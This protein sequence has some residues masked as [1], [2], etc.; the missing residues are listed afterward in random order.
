MEP[1]TRKTPRGWKRI[2]KTATAV[3]AELEECEIA[4]KSDT[5]S[6]LTL[7]PAAADEASDRVAGTLTAAAA[8]SREVCA[9]CGGGGDPV[10]RT[11]GGL[12]T[13]CQ[14]CRAKSDEGAAARMAATETQAG[15]ARARGSGRQG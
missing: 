13:R 4:I 11:D 9:G 1:Q 6:W 12:T 14:D 2:E 15:S 7:T 5:T 8:L 10:R 3:A